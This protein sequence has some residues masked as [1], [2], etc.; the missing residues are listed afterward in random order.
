[1][2]YEV[3]TEYLTLNS[4]FSITKDRNGRLFPDQQKVLHFLRKISRKML[5]TQFILNIIRQS[6]PNKIPSRHTML[7]Q[8]RC[9]IVRCRKTRHRR[10][11]DT[12]FL[13]G[14]ILS[15]REYIFLKKTLYNIM[16]IFCIW[17]A[18]ICLKAN[19]HYEEAGY[20]YHVVP[21]KKLVFISTTSEEW[22]ADS[23][24]GRTCVDSNWYSNNI[25][26]RS[27]LP[28]REFIPNKMF[29]MWVGNCFKQNT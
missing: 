23:T 27:L 19:P 7:F 26:T 1:M 12:V 3:H 24:L 6:I 2:L 21:S 11:N 5:I 16:D 28:V 10:W 14:L 17:E 29:V 4:D 8:R 15:I 25:T 18:F 9:D 22:T 13:Q 20:F